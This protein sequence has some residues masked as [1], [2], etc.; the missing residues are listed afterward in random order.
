MALRHLTPS[1]RTKL[2]PMFEMQPRETRSLLDRIVRQ[3][4]RSWIRDLPL[5]LDVDRDY[6]IDGRGEAIQNLA[7]A[8]DHMRFNG[9]RIIPVTG[10]KRSDEYQS[11][12]RSEL[13]QGRGELCIRLHSEDWFDLPSLNNGIAQI[14]SFFQKPLGEMH[15]VLD[16]GAFLPS[17]AGTIVTSAATTINSLNNLKDFQSLVIAGT[18]FPYQTPSRRE[19]VNRLPRSEWQVWTALQKEGVIKRKPDF[20]DYT[21]VHPQFPDIDF[22]FV[23]IAP[24]IKYTS[25]TEW[26]FIRWGSGYRGDFSGFHDVCQLMVGE[27]EYKGPSFSWGDR[28]IA[29]CAADATITGNPGQW[30]TIGINHHVTFVVQQIAN[31]SVT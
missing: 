11:V 10:L 2:A 9:Y 15:I 24:K 29:E 30:V 23:E 31:P 28:R 22:R 4:E 7:Y 14:S 27:A 12:I 26:L 19:A 16:F 8:L 18:A 21:I 1:I 6:L 5:F 25:D 13:E 20:G 17:Q 3:I